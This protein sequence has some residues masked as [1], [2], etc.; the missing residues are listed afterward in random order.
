MDRQTQRKDL[1]Q[2]VTDAIVAHLEAGTPPWE[3]DWIGAEARLPYNLTSGKPYR[4]VNILALWITALKRGYL[5]AGWLT[6][7]Q[8]HNLGA[9]V[10]AGEKGTHIVFW[11]RNDDDNDGEAAD[12]GEG[13]EAPNKPAM[14]ARWYTVFNVAQIDGLPD[15]DPLPTRTDA[16]RIDD[17][18]RFFAACGAQVIHESSNPGYSASLDCIRIPAIDAFKTSAGYYAALAHEHAHWTGHKSRLN[19]E[20]ANRF[21]S[22]AYAAEELIA[23]LGAAFVCAQLGI[24]YK[25]EQHASYLDS[26]LRVL[27]ADKRAIFT[28][29]SAATRAVDFLN[30]LQSQTEHAAA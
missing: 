10:R 7:K 3:R 19:R 24:P 1:Y 9:N 11:Q 2:E 14:F 12:L 15:A 28:A 17:A 8:A 4:G 22:D 5:R 25:L 18:D 16:E 6:Y 27:K 23:E 29:A 13:A 26:W 21:K 30:G 20:L